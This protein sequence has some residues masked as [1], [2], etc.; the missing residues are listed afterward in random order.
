MWE[1]EIRGGVNGW[2]GLLVDGG[3]KG[4]LMVGGMDGWRF[5]DWEYGFCVWVARYGM[6]VF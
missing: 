3:M 6:R 2:M 4:G 1:V 5:F